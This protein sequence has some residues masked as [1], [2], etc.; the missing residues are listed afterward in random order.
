[1]GRLPIRPGSSDCSPIGCS[2]IG[3]SSIECGSIRC[4]SIACGSIRSCHGRPLGT[5]GGLQSRRRDDREGHDEAPRRAIASP[6]R[7][8]LAVSRAAGAGD[9]IHQTA[10]TFVTSPVAATRHDWIALL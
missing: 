5:I 3:C 9:V 1:M 6:Q 8:E 4:G 10:C 2:S 7:S